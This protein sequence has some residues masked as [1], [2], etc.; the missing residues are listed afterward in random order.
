[1]LETLYCI[2]LIALYILVNVIKKKMLNKLDNKGIATINICLDV[3][4]FLGFLLG[5][6]L[7]LGFDFSKFKVGFKDFIEFQ[8]SS[9]IWSIIVVIIASTL[10]GITKTLLFK[11]Y[12]KNILEVK[13]QNT[14]SKVLM[15]LIRYAA[16]IIC[17]IVILG[18]WKVNVMPALAGLGIVGL[19]VGLGAQKLIS[20]FVAGLFIVFEHHFDVGD[21]IIVGDFK[22]EVI[23]I[24]LKTTKIR[25]WRG[26]V[27]II[28]NGD[29]TDIINDSLY[30]TV[31]DISVSIG[32]G[33]DI[34]KVREIIDKGLADKFKGRPEL[35]DLPHTIGVGNLGDSGIEIVVVGTTKPES[36]YQISRDV[37][38]EIKAICDS[39]NIEIPFPQIVVHGVRQDD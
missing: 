34:A 28:A 30:N 12:K 3:A 38:Q 25:D 29:L 2:I 11:K 35:V 33:E 39:N 24:G 8:G 10:L 36:H 9:L 31:F 19:V 13:R 4:I 14:I 15:S 17:V 27:K 37:R 32:Y 21:T 18:I 22:G 6:A 7:I 23:D 16:Y 20:D 5:I 26:R 1:M